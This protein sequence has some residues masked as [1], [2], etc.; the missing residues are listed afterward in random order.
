[1]ESD[2]RDPL[3]GETFQQVIKCREIK[4]VHPKTLHHYGSNLSD[5]GRNYAGLKIEKC[6]PKN[7]PQNLKPA[8]YAGTI[9][10]QNLW[11]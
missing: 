9:L 4:L 10:A 2:S 6:V 7:Q 11:E 1:M 3:L 8:R 5:M